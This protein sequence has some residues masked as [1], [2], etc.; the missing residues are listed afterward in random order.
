MRLPLQAKIS[1][2]VAVIILISSGI[3]TYYFTA[4]HSRSKENGRVLRGMAL[5]HSLSKSAEEGLINEDL[6]LIKKASYVIKAPDV[7]LAQVY[8]DIWE[9]VDAYPFERLKDLPAP[10][11]VDHF[12]NDPSPFYVKTKSTFDFYSPVFYKASEETAPVTI[13]YV[14]IVVS[15]ADVQKELRIIVRNNIIL[16]LVITLIAFFAIHIL[17][18]RMVIRPVLDLH[19]SVSRY[20]EGSLPDAVSV[21]AADE[22][23]ELALE[24]NNM[25][26]A[27]RERNEKLVESE[28]RIKSLFERVEHA[29]F[30]LDSEGN[31]IEANTKFTKMFGPV[32]NIRNLLSSEKKAQEY[33]T[34]SLSSKVVHAEERLMDK[35]G[36]EIVV[37]LSMYPEIDGNGNVEGYDGYIID[38][39]EKKRL[40]ERLIR[41]QKME[42]VGTL[43]GG[44]AH[45]FNNLL[46]AILGYSEIMQSMVKEGDEYY[47]PVNII[48]Q[49]A[50][51]GAEFGR[52]ILTITRKEK[53]ETKPVTI[54]DVITNSLDLLQRTLPKDIEIIVKLSDDIP[55]INADPSQIQQVIVNLAINARDAM[56]E[57][58]KLFIETSTISDRNDLPGDMHDVR[59][60]FIKISVADTGTG[61]DME[62]QSKI[63]DPFFTTKEVGKGTGLG[64]YIVHSIVTNHGG[65][66]NL[67][68]EPL[69]GTQFNI[70]L[71]VTGV[72]EPEAARDEEDL[73]GSGTLLVIDDESDVRELCKDLLTT[74]GYTVLLA[75]S[76]SA[77]INVYRE[78]KDEISLVILDMIMPKMGGRE[79]FQN[80]KTIDPEVKIL[81]CS[82]FGQNG[83]AGIEELLRKGAVEFVQKP[84]SRH[85]IGLALKKALS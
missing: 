13:G 35:N 65:Y 81:L 9:P 5:V 33:L 23:G 19:K 34:H 41:S 42:A 75:D 37:L 18:S 6:D 21:H 38:I 12:R 16:S 80:L 57:G 17:I 53:I 71:P 56:P 52:K 4:A 27:I 72:S 39:T 32:K 58:G 25:S 40:E 20:K 11:A 44:M 68:S 1:V 49:A 55:L 7:T 48:Y 67:Y 64:L 54:N 14:R 85:A 31:L 28:E 15:S 79:V 22:I 77:G 61:I 29:I 43:V 45:E 73:R 66:I 70:Y 36:N 26:R 51:R 47:K 50:T 78:K 24:F 2:L 10:E 8:S 3:S 46:T 30:G 62:T 76:G 63:F 59:R 69:R 82:G 84:F 60:S 74:L 83:F